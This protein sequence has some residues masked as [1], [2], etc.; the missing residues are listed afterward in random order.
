MITFLAALDGAFARVLNLLVLVTSLVVTAALVLLV[1][2]RAGF[3][4]PLTGMH[5]AS[6]LAAM[7]LYMAGATLA[8]RNGRHL[9]VD[10]LAT[11][12]T[13]RRARAIH[14]L[15]IAAITAVVAGLFCFWVW[16]MFAWGMKRPQTI[17]VLGL[18]LWLAQAPLA[19]AA[20]TAVLYA[21]RDMAR[22]VCTLGR[23]GEGG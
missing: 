18:P 11:G 2:A 23:P 6:M 12:L 9:T 19:L 21:L 7:W 14:R 3:D 15:I 4:L 22:A 5:E 16:K 20:V 10:F 13:G 8:T 1:T 17:P